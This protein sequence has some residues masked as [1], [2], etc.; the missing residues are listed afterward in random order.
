MEWVVDMEEEVMEEDILPN[1]AVIV[2]R[3]GIPL[4][5]AIKKHGFPPHFKFKN[6]NYHQS[7]AAFHNI[8]FNN[9]EQNHE[10]SKSEVESQPIGFTPEQYQTLLALLQQVKSSDNVSSQVSVIPSN[11]TTQTGNR[12]I[13]SFSSWIIDS[14]ATDHICSSLTY[15]TSY[16]QIDPIYVKLPNG[17]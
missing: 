2:E 15:F 11:M 14:G 16:H 17:N 9:N 3:Q 10:G 5:H 1:F 13:S 4:I 12:F 7:H 8:N 6:Q